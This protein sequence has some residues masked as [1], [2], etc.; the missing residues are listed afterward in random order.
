HVFK[1]ANL[2]QTTL[3]SNAVKNKILVDTETGVHR[4]KAKAAA[5]KA[6]IDEQLRQRL[7]ALKNQNLSWENSVLKM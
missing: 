3:L 5:E 7:E 4:A 2:E 1:M 6:L